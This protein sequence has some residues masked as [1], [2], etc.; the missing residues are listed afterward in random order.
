QQILSKA[1]IQE[2]T[3]MHVDAAHTRGADGYGYYWWVP[4]DKFLG[5]FEAVGR[6]GQRITV[7]PA[8]DLVL[9]YNGGG[10]D[11]SVLAPFILKS[12]KSDGALTKN[13]EAVLRLGKEI[14]TALRPPSPQPSRKPP[15]LAATISGREFALSANG[16]DL[17]RL[18]I[19]FTNP[20]EAA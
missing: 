16:L 14:E 6:G 12:I 8:K 2:A 19:N 1:W 13:P 10:F 17:R 11:P 15:V 18:S 5:V 7:W 4:G 20:A 9:V 3:R